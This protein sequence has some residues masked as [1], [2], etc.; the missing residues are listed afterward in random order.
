MQVAM[1]QS[2]LPSSAWPVRVAL[3]MDEDFLAA[4]QVYDNDDALG[5]L[6]PSTPTIAEPGSFGTN[7]YTTNNQD[8][9]TSNDS[10]PAGGF[11]NKCYICG[12]SGHWAIS[13]NK[14]Q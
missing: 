8:Q 2:M 14:N 10:Y 11:E 13:C 1:I 12:K 5:Q 7:V 9:F 3:E 6:K 4:S